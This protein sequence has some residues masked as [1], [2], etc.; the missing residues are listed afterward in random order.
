MH[1]PTATTE[2]VLADGSGRITVLDPDHPDPHHPLAVIDLD[3]YHP[4]HLDLAITSTARI[5]TSNADPDTDSCPPE[6]T[7]TIQ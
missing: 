5:C 3:L 7:P 4:G 1:S 6:R 2:L